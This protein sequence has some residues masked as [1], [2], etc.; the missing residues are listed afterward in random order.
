MIAGPSLFSRKSRNCNQTVAE[1]SKCNYVN[2]FYLLCLRNSNV[3]NDSNE[4]WPFDRKCL[5][6]FWSHS[7]DFI[8]EFALVSLFVSNFISL[9]TPNWHENAP[10][11]LQWT[12]P[13][14][15]QC[16]ATSLAQSIWLKF[17]FCKTEY[18]F[19]HCQFGEFELR[20]SRRTESSLSSHWELPR[21]L[22][23]F[24]ESISKTFEIFWNVLNY[25]LSS[26][27][28]L[29]SDWEPVKFYF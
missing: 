13:I 15:V 11:S 17:G 28:L 27:L 5:C 8:I 9:A 1:L 4:I 24:P 10:K 16:W 21:E 3:S 19:F 2:L 18:L 6:I 25:D 14:Q 7:I 29:H 12:A 26:K 20:D 23:F 22:S